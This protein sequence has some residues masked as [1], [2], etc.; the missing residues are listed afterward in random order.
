LLLGQ[1]L[2]KVSLVVDRD[3]VSVAAQF[4]SGY[5]FLKMFGVSGGMPTR[6]ALTRNQLPSILMALGLPSEAAQL[7]VPLG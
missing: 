2:E 6:V 3:T 4:D 5:D 7:L 1:E